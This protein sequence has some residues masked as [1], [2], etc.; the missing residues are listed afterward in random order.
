LSFTARFAPGESPATIALHT[1]EMNPG[2][3]HQLSSFTLHGMDT[4]VEQL[5][6]ASQFLKKFEI[7]AESKASG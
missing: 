5:P 1:E 2:M 3:M 7:P 6:D 4:P